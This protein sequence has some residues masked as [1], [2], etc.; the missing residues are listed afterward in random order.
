MTIKDPENKN[1]ILDILVYDANDED[2]DN[3]MS[4]TQ[5]TKTLSSPS[6]VDPIMYV[7]TWQKRKQTR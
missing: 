7:D 6:S 3:Q 2:N 5:Y 4:K 1:I